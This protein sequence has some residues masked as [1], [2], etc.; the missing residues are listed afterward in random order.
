MDLRL[1]LQVTLLY[2]VSAEIIRTTFL[3]ALCTG[4]RSVGVAWG[5]YSK[6][7]MDSGRFNVIVDSV[8][9]L[10]LLIEHELREV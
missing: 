5:S 6:A 9:Q 4:M 1:F 7:Q 10:R 2:T 3:P 8:D